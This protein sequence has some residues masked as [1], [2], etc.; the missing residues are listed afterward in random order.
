[1]KLKLTCKRGGPPDFEGSTGSSVSAAQRAAAS[2]HL[3]R[4]HAITW[5]FDLAPR[6]IALPRPRRDAAS[7]RRSSAATRTGPQAGSPI[8][9][10][11]MEARLHLA[12]DQPHPLYDSRQLLPYGA[13][14]RLDRVS[15]GSEAGSISP[16]RFPMAFS[17]EVEEP[18]SPA[19][20]CV[21][22]QKRRS[23]EFLGFA[24]RFGPPEP[25]VVDQVPPFRARDILILSNVVRERQPAG[26]ADA[27]PFSTPTI[28]TWRCPRGRRCCS[29]PG[30]SRAG[31][32]I[33]RTSTR[34]LHLPTR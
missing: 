8:S 30:A 25:H 17:V 13:L 11:P 22:R 21:P 3:R 27:G 4:L 7:P 2:R 6:G 1:M 31:D 33:L 32:T 19:R 29:S 5:Q 24:R 20:S 26:L 18:S 10:G 9:S 12:Y 16:G 28:R 14:K 34:L 15:P 23:R